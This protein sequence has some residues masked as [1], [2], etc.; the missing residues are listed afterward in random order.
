MEI[1]VKLPDELAAD[2]EHFQ[3]SGLHL[4]D[5]EGDAWLAALERG[6]KPEL[7]ELHA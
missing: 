3:S 6:L 1:T 2:W 4:S 5:E 7:P